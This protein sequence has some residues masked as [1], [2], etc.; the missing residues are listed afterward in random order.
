MAGVTPRLFYFMY[1]HTF[2]NADVVWHDDGSIETRYY[3]IPQDLGVKMN[4]ALT[5][6]D[7]DYIMEMVGQKIDK[8]G[9]Q[10]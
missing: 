3:F 2:V 7:M 9:S 8:K 4:E 5:Q 10:N 1:G 6:D